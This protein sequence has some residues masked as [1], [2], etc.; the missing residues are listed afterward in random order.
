MQLTKNFSLGELIRSETAQSMKID[1]SVPKA[2]MGN[3]QRLADFLQSLRD[4]LGKPV[5]IT[6]GYRSPALNAALG[7]ASPTSAHMKALAADIRVP[8][9]TPEAL[10]Q[11]IINSDLEYDQ[12]I[13]EYSQWV[14]VGLSETKPRMQK[15]RATRNSKRRTVYT[16]I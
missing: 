7:E 12:V 8:G 9:M 14:H 3:A 11:F 5:I 10:F 15:V 13:Q 16:L 6:S 1:N 4:A 2:L